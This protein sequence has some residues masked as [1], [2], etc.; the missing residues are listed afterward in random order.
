MSCRVGGEVFVLEMGDPVKIIELARNMIRLAGLEPDVDIGIEVVGRRPGEKIHEELFNPGER[1]Q[2]T[3]AEKIVSA[4]RPPLAPEW[5]ESAFARIEELVYGGDAAGLAGAV[6]ELSTERALAVTGGSEPARLAAGHKAGPPPAAA[7]VLPSSMEI[8]EQIGSYA[9]LAAIVGLAVLSALYFSQARDVKRLR[10]W[11]GR[12]PERTAP[13]RA[14]ARG[15]AAPAQARAGPA[16]RAAGSRSQPGP[17]GRAEAAAGPAARPHRRSPASAGARPATA[18][19]AAAAAGGAAAATAERPSGPGAAT[20][21]GQ[22][23]QGPGDQKPADPGANG[24][25]PP[26]DARGLRPP[27]AGRAPRRDTDAPRDRAADTA[28]RPTRPATRPT[29]RSPRPPAVTPENTEPP[30]QAVPPTIPA[31]PARAATPAGQARPTL[32][33]PPRFA[34]TTPPGASARRSPRRSSRPARAAATAVPAPAASVA[35]GSPRSWWPA[36]S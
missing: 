1:P 29:G 10:E 23:K 4:V 3:H 14:A 16:G 28:R 6:S 25:K 36:S 22:G 35:A 24:E 26:E 15:G 30:T 2:P 13:A 11:A 34:R 9:G 17:P 12:A 33:T 20:P 8:I 31:P 18:T 5:V 7:K 19:A 21:A 27:P 32:P